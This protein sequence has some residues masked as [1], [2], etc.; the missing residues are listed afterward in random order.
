MRLLTFT[1]PRTC[2]SYGDRSFATAWPHLWNSLPSHLQ[3][4]DI[5]Y[6]DFKRQLK[7]FLFRE[8]AAQCIVTLALC[9]LYKYSFFLTY[10]LTYLLTYKTSNGKSFSLVVYK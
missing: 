7:T 3:H 6:N 10:L 8:T 4:S 9:V 5:G 1:V 2:N